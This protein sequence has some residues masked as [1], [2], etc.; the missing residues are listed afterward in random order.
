VNLPPGDT[1]LFHKHRYATAYVLISDALVATQREGDEEWKHPGQRPLRPAGTLMDRSDYAI[2][3]FAHRVRNLDKRTLKL[4]ALVNVA[5]QG[6]EA[7]ESEPDGPLDNAWFGEHRL[8]LSAA[9]QSHPLVFGNPVVVVQVSAG[10]S[11]AVPVDPRL[12]RSAI[13]NVK[14]VPGAWS[15]HEKGSAFRLRNLGDTGADLVIIEVK[16]GPG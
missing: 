4:V 13:Q 11:D 8:S 14:T 7:G 3:P 12:E 16:P 2:N 10:R 1:T 5:S 6:T 9:A 15:W